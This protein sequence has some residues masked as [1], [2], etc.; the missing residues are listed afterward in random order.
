MTMAPCLKIELIFK[1]SCVEKCVDKF[2]KVNQR[3]MKTYV[4]V[5]SKINEKRMIEYENQLKQA[6]AESQAQQ[7]ET[8]QEPIIEAKN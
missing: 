8:Q 5:Q 4:E 7:P 1:H 3:L 6:E 2:A